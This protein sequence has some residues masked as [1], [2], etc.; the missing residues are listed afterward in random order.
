[1]GIRISSLTPALAKSD[2]DP[3]AAAQ[4][5]VPVSYAGTTSEAQYPSFGDDAQFD[6]VTQQGHNFVIGEALTKIP[7]N[8]YYQRAILTDY[9][10]GNVIGV[11]TAVGTGANINKFVLTYSGKAAIG[12]LGAYTNITLVPGTV[13][14]LS[15][16]TAGLCE[17]RSS[18]YLSLVKPV[19]FCLTTSTVYVVPDREVTTLQN[20]VVTQANLTFGASAF[21][22]VDTGTANAIV[23]GFTPA[24]AAPYTAPVA[25]KVKMAATNTGATT[26]NIDT[27]GLKDVKKVTSAGVVALAAG[28][29]VIGGTYDMVYDGTQ[30]IVTN[31]TQTMLVNTS[32]S[33]LAVLCNPA[34]STT[35]R[36]VTFAHGAGA[37]PTSSRWYIVCISAD[38]GYAENDEVAVT[39]VFYH[40]TFYQDGSEQWRSPI[41]TEYAN[42]TVVG[43]KV[44]GWN[45]G[46]GYSISPI[47]IYE[48]DMGP[49]TLASWKLRNR[50]IV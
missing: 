26:I 27:Q 16:S 13:Y 6:I 33:T 5:M 28:N 50:T 4:P 47:N 21:Y 35:D 17:A 43:A 34:T 1:M 10:N 11:V 30:F 7:G 24:F 32:T 18:T 14:C 25:I 8:S 3:F 45:P 37:I 48:P 19:F 12:G 31:P 23:V 42:A 46:D 39:G 38:A 29:L 9:D 44:R 15:G 36:T 20:R 2:I 41:L 40:D 49:I 22:A